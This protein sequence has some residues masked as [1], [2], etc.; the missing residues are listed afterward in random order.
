MNILALLL[1]V[2]ILQNICVG[3]KVLVNKINE[4]SF[5]IYVMMISL[6]NSPFPFGNAGGCIVLTNIPNKLFCE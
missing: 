3:P 6:T 2:K 4:L 5:D 1:T